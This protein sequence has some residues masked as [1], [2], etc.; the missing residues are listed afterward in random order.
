[1]SW[2]VKSWII[3]S[4]ETEICMWMC[5]IGSFLV[6]SEFE[7]FSGVWVRA[8]CKWPAEV[9]VLAQISPSAVKSLKLWLFL[10]IGRWLPRFYWLNNCCSR[11]ILLTVQGNFFHR[12]NYYWVSAAGLSVSLQMNS[13]L[14][15]CQNRMWCDVFGR[16]SEASYW[17]TASVQRW[18][19]DPSDSS[20][21]IKIFWETPLLRP[22]QLS[23]F[24]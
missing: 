20:L 14:G 21:W 1:M 23:P 10:H 18:S 12:D 15:V 8:F 5:R 17:V 4:E 2:L 7:G 24:E 3:Q 6:N 13:L 16:F 11:L 19:S 9:E 22:T